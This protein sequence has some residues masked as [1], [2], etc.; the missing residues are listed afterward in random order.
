MFASA[1]A[2]VV[3][4]FPFFSFV[5][6]CWSFGTHANCIKRIERVLWTLE[7]GRTVGVLGGFRCRRLFTI[8]Y[9]VFGFNQYTSCST[10]SSIYSS[11]CVQ[12]VCCARSE[13]VTKQNWFNSISQ[14]LDRFSMRT[15]VKILPLLITCLVYR[16]QYSR[17]LCSARLIIFLF[18]SS[19]SS[20]FRCSRLFLSVTRMW[21][22]M[23]IGS[24][25][26]TNVSSPTDL[27]RHNNSAHI[28][29]YDSPN[30]VLK[31]PRISEG[32]TT[33]DQLWQTMT[34]CI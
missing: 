10:H 2:P 28:Q 24:V 8:E 1:S 22:H 6:L 4:S 31:R 27:H 7:D 25:T 17:K 18:I 20:H 5:W 32:W 12:N 21:P 11:V 16:C 15:P 34:K 9:I 14:A 29:D 3:L 23:Q 26:P 19:W 33:A 13:R 30:Q